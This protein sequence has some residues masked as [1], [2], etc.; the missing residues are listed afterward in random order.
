[1]P[2]ADQWRYSNALEAASSGKELRFFRTDAAGTPRDGFHSGHLA[3]KAQVSEPPAIV[4]SG[5]HE[6]P[7]L[8]LAK[9]AANEN[10]SSQFRA[11]QKRAITF[12]S[13][14]FAH[15][16][17]VAGQMHLTLVCEADTP[18]FDLWPEVLMLLAPPAPRIAAE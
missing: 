14:P 4:V 6:L 16:T 15:D 8:E 18:D 9:Y 3:A 13:E 10:L 2:G 11:F 1:M 5:P 12:H 7:G 17:E